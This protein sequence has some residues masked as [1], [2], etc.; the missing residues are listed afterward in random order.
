MF[1]WGSKT[2][3][4]AFRLHQ[5]IAQGGS[6]YST[7]ERA[8]PRFLT[9]EG[10]YK[11]TN[12]RLLYPLVF[13]RECG[14]DYYVVKFDRDRELITPLLP[15]SI[16]TDENEN[17]ISP[18]YLTLDEPELWSAEHLD[19]LP[20]SWFKETQRDGRVLKKEHE[21]Y[22]PQQ[23]FVNPNGTIAL[24][25]IG[26]GS[27]KPTPCW[28]VPRPFKICLNCKVVHN[29][30]KNEFTK[31]SRL[32]SEGRSTATTLLSISTV[33]KLKATLPLDSTAAKVLS[34]T[35]NRQD[36]SLQAGHFN[37][38]VQ[39]SFLIKDSRS[40]RSKPTSGGGSQTNGFSPNRLCRTTC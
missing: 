7:L 29:G 24:T 37:D 22:N 34:F 16:D 39:T 10:Q 36:A 30:R 38:F 35:D 18:G 27:E 1:L 6:V 4:L 3:G 21:K 20:D 17:D 32:S 15:N 8:E 33:S 28:F 11:T 19:S 9:L 25:G 23:L 40:I 12:D 13:C 2:K 5:F 26:N 31:L 14:Q